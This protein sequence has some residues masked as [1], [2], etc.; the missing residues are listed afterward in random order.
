MDLH[1]RAVEERADL[2]ALGVFGAGWR[3][4]GWVEPHVR[5]TEY[6]L[7]T[8]GEA[9]R[10]GDDG[11]TFGRTG[12]EWRGDREHVYLYTLKLA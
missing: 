3:F 6:E 12:A 4:G 9:T 10:R 1:F 5:G 2:L 7:R 8:L 11:R